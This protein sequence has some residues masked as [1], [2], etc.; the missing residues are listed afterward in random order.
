MAA[1]A[2]LV[3]KFSTDVAGAQQGLAQLAASVATNMKSISTAATLASKT[4]SAVMAEGTQKAIADA[5]K[6]GDWGKVGIAI[7]QSFRRGL[8]ES[9]A[10]AASQVDKFNLAVKG[11]G[12]AAKYGP[13]VAKVAFAAHNPVLALGI[14]LLQ[15][16]LRGIL[17]AGTAVGGLAAAW[18]LSSLA[19]KAARDRLDEY[20]KIATSSRGV[21]VGTSFYQAW[22]AQAKELNVETSD[23]VGMLNRARQA[24]TV[25]IGEGRNSSS[26]EGLNRLQQHVSAGNLSGADLQAYQGAS[27]Q[28]A[29][30]RVVLNLIQQLQV[31]GR[32]LAAFDLANTFFGT[33][34]ERQLRDGVDMIGKM[35]AALDGVKSSGGARIV[36]EE[37]IANAQRMRAELDA[38]HN[39]LAE[40]TSSLLKQISL[41]EQDILQSAIEWEQSLVRV[42]ETLRDAATWVQTIVNKLDDA[43]R[44]AAPDWLTE[45]KG[46]ARG[47]RGRD[48]TAEILGGN[49]VQGT[50]DMVN[51][52]NRRTT[53]AA[54]TT[55]FPDQASDAYGPPAPPAQAETVALPDINVRGDRSRAL[56]DLHPRAAA[57]GGNGNAADQVKTFIDQLSKQAAAEEA[58]AKTLGMSNLAKQEAVNLAKAQEAARVRGTPLTDA[59]TAAVKKQTDAYNE[60][61]DKIDAFNKAQED[62]KSLASTMAQSFEG[63]IEGMITSGNR[64]SD[65]LRTIAS[66]FE[67]MALK[68]LLT[69]EGPL[70]SSFGTAASPDAK[71]VAAGSGGILGALIGGGASLLSGAASGKSS[72]GSSSGLFGNLFSGLF[73]DG[74]AIPAGHWGIA[75]EA[76]PEIIQGPANIVPTRQIAA[77]MSAGGS[78]GS[79][80]GHT[81]NIDARGAQQGVAEQ[82]HAVMSG[83]LTAY[84]KSLNRS[85]P[86]R[87]R[88]VQR[89][90]G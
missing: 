84:D 2:P 69:G 21:G 33:G 48:W 27:S 32:Q 1:S 36:S 40:V 24:A 89:R 17:L 4:F 65:T 68:A 34:F 87:L 61:K 35:R 23:L 39:Q 80:S 3:L 44:I 38:I 11:T 76:G 70:A 78:S 72:S 15:P 62:A 28:E 58:E 41:G 25:S 9:V 14:Q 30:L 54:L 6:N 81:I 20:V 18:E 31:S 64:L 45:L 86:G 57:A 59:E 90:F 75:G 63:A 71:G 26:S 42:I 77:A 60:A 16:Y 13:E 46:W 67:S 43:S 52:F 10:A 7:S 83:A 47:S 55:L 51:T 66:S 49:I 5:R 50:A 8:G 29:R 37:E 88:T 82:I 74:G 12:I 56:P 79:S 22:T 85:L 19:E 73:A 53:N